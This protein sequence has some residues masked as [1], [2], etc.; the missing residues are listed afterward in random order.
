MSATVRVFVAATPRFSRAC[1]RHELAVVGFL[2]VDVAGNNHPFLA[3]GHGLGVVGIAVGVADFHAPGLRFDRMIVRASV[4]LQLSQTAFD[5]FAQ[6]LA[7]GQSGGQTVS[8]L[9]QVRVFFHDGQFDLVQGG[10]KLGEQFFHVFLAPPLGAATG[11]LN[12]RAVQGLQ[13]QTDGPGAHGHLHRLFEDLA[14]GLFVVAPETPERVVIGPDQ[15]G[16]P[17]QREM[18]AAGGLQFA[19]RTDPVVVAVKPDL[20]EQARMVRRAAFHSGRQGESQ[21]GQIQLV[22][23]LAQETRRVIGGHT[24]FERGWKKKLLAV[25]GSDWLCHRSVR[26][27]PNPKCYRVLRACCFVETI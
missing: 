24:V 17:E 12:F 23:K 2:T 21:R 6:G 11:G 5:F 25:V 4:G 18:F 3:I 7:P 22:H 1:C 19:G 16:E 8:G 13:G 20:Q 27:L 26:R 15:A 10:V 9:I 14:Q